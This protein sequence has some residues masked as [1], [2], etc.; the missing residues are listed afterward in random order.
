M[1]QAIEKGMKS[2]L[3]SIRGVL[4]NEAEKVH[5]GFWQREHTTKQMLAAT[6]VWLSESHTPIPWWMLLAMMFDPELTCI[7]ILIAVVITNK[8]EPSEG[9]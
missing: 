4:Q 2:K 8:C 6:A 7:T 5:F 1:N 9:Y 3:E